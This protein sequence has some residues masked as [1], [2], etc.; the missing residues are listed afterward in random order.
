MENN[1]CF[2][3]MAYSSIFA[4]HNIIHVSRYT[5]DSGAVGQKLRAEKETVTML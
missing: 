2:W 4:E 3:K 5:F 1:F